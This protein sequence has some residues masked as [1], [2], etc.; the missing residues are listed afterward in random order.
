VTVSPVSKEPD[1]K[2]AVAKVT[3][4][5]ADA[6]IVYQ[7]DVIGAGAKGEGVKIPDDQNVVADYPV[8]IVKATKNRAAS[9]AFVD[10]AVKG[11][12]QDALKQRGFL[13]AT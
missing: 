11:R 5:E 4:Q 3:S 13:P 9:A 7:T 1:V 8:A 12:G 10:A 6:T 2:S